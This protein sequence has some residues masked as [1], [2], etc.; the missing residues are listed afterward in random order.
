[1][2][3]TWAP[4]RK[5]KCVGCATDG[6]SVAGRE[7][8]YLCEALS[9]GCDGLGIGVMCI[10]CLTR[11]CLPRMPCLCMCVC[12]SVMRRRRWNHKDSRMDG[13]NRRWMWRRGWESETSAGTEVDV[14]TPEWKWKWPSEP[15]IQQGCVVTF[16]ADPSR[17]TQRMGA[18]QGRNATAAAAAQQGEAAADFRLMAWKRPGEGGCVDVWMPCWMR[19]AS[20]GPKLV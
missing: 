15:S 13:W 5:C 14:G 7:I 11:G 8:G 18:G 1:M 16:L 4:K 9:R 19:V 6:A 10:L 2:T 3:K 17:D 20:C 12:M